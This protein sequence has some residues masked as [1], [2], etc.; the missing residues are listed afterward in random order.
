MKRNIPNFGQRGAPV[1]G[2]W[3]KL[4]TLETI[5]LLA[6]AGF[7]FVILDL[8]HSPL[9]LEAAYASLVVAQGLGMNVFARLPDLTRSYV[10]RLLDAGIDGLIVPQVST[11]EQADT[12][13]RSMLFPPRG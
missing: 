11:A 12:V 4:R 3:V 9:A 8:E 13:V 6:E 10:Q 2:T 1:F 7:G 5:E